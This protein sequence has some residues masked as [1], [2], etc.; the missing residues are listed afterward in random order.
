MWVYVNDGRPRGDASLLLLDITVQIE[1]RPEEHKDLLGYYM[2]MPML[3]I[4]IYTKANPKRVL[5]K[6]VAACQA[7]VL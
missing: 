2:Q 5:K 6:Y 7:E 1:E 4:I 3:V